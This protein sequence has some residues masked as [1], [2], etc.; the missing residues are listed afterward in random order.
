MP[1]NKT[2]EPIFQIQNC[3]PQQPMKFDHEAAK[4]EVIQFLSSPLTYH[5]QTWYIDP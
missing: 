2:Q 4:Q 5:N 1:H 3:W